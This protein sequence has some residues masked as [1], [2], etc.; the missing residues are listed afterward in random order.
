[1]KILNLTPAQQHHLTEMLSVIMTQLISFQF[2]DV[3]QDQVLMRQ[4]AYLKGKFDTLKL[5]LEDN[6]EVPAVE[7]P[8]QE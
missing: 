4:H 1:M 3:T 6:F 5:L 2:N 8:T 7:T